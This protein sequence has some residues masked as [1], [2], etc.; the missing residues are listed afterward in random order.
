[1]RNKTHQQRGRASGGRWPLQ[2]GAATLEDSWEG[3]SSQGRSGQGAS[4]PCLVVCQHD[5]IRVVSERA[6]LRWAESVQAT[7]ARTVTHSPNVI[8]CT[9]ALKRAHCTLVCWP[10][11]SRWPRGKDGQG[12]EA[13]TQCRTHNAVLTSL[14]HSGRSINRTQK[15]LRKRMSSA[16]FLGGILGG[17]DRSVVQERLKRTQNA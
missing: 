8:Q 15:G 6:A 11:N 17:G 4:S 12:R 2:R 14:S 7:N 5:N 3:S 13:K 10:A 16:A 9:R 1:M